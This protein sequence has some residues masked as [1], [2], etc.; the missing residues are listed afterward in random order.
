MTSE[1]E[2]VGIAAGAWMAGRSPAILIQNSGFCDAINPICSLLH[3]FRI[4]IP[5]FVSVRG[6]FGIKDEPQHDVIGGR[7]LSIVES[8]GLF[9]AVLPAGP[10]EMRLE[11]ASLFD[12]AI[13]AGR[14]LVVAVPVGTL[15]QD[16]HPSAAAADAHDPKTRLAPA[17]P[18]FH[19]SDPDVEGDCG[20]RQQVLAA[21]K[22][23]VP[24]SSVFVCSTGFIGRDLFQLGDADRQIYIAGS[25]GCASAIGFGISRYSDRTVVVLDGDGAALM[26][27]GNM[28]TIGVEGTGK[29][30]HFVLNNGVYESTGGQH[31]FARAVDFAAIAKACGYAADSTKVASIE[32][33]EKVVADRCRNLRR[34]SPILF[35]TL[36]SARSP[37]PSG[38]P[39][40]SYPEQARRLRTALQRDHE[41]VRLRD[42][43]ALVSMKGDRRD[44]R[45][46]ETT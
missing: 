10:D 12:C 2:G 36:L 30:M 27:L 39:D 32:R 41:A 8:L 14:S 43:L 34:G 16:T 38:R 37:K 18:P 1:A 5:F 3:T 6:G 22:R 42:E 4:P 23:S 40:V 28:A 20:F 26:R 17:L 13:G 25:M 19:A 21:I 7:F 45:R 11:I 15:A 46:T 9:S 44:N 24:A 29:L 35:D 31:N 33:L